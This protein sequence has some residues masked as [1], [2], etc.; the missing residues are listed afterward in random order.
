VIGRHKVMAVS[1]MAIWILL[2]VVGSMLVTSVAVALLTSGYLAGWFRSRRMVDPVDGELLITAGSGP[3]GQSR[4]AKYRLHG[5]VTGPDLPATAITHAGY[6]RNT[7]WPFPGAKLPVRVDRAEP[8]R[9]LIRWNRVPTGRQ[10]AAEM[11]DR[12][13]EAM[14]GQAP[15]EPPPGMSNGAHHPDADRIAAAVRDSLLKIGLPGGRVE[16]QTKVQT[17]VV[18]GS[19]VVA[20]G[21][22]FAAAATVATT[23]VVTASR[24]VPAP[25]G[26]TRPPGGVVELTLEVARADGTRYPAT[27]GVLFSSTER[28]VRYGMVGAQLPVRVDPAN[29]TRVVID[30]AALD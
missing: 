7:R 13:A 22:T 26:E 25:P 24:E 6:A 8:S 11:T 9:L 19:R 20:G 16:V 15:P 14:R 12:L 28:R 2:S 18:R 17:H 27:A 29:P 30:A 21:S 5:V 23:A 3:S 10:T 1:G 4:Y